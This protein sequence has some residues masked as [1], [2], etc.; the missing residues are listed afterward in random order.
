MLLNSIDNHGV[1]KYSDKRS[2]IDI[3]FRNIFRRLIFSSKIYNQLSKFRDKYSRPLKTKETNFLDLETK[4]DLSSAASK[5][6]KNII[7]MDVISRSQ[8]AEYFALLQP[9]L[10][11]S[12]DY[13]NKEKS[14][15]LKDKRYIKKIRYL[16]S[17]LRNYCN[18]LSF[19]IDISKNKK[20]I[21]SDFFY[22]DPR[23]PNSDGNKLI[24][25]EIINHIGKDLANDY[26]K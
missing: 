7:F 18:D 3:S 9:T 25:E 4:K 5:W 6:K 20:L 21:S 17:E 26:S 14:C 13:C 19:C 8:G 15:L 24:S 16:Y 22:T 23:H 1:I 2:F 10:G 12:N 11:L